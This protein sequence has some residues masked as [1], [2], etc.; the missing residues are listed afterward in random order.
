MSALD[1]YLQGVF[2]D[3]KRHVEGWKN[4]EGKSVLVCIAMGCPLVH[5]FLALQTQEWKDTHIRANLMISSTHAG[6]AEALSTLI[7]GSPYTGEHGLGY[8]FLFNILGSAP[9]F[10]W[11]LP[12][13]HEDKVVLTTRDR[14]YK[15]T[16]ADYQAIMQQIG[17]PR[18]KTLYTIVSG[19]D[20]VN[21]WSFRE[22][23]APGVPVVSWY[24]YNVATPEVLDLEQITHGRRTKEHFKCKT[25]SR[26]YGKPPNRGGVCLFGDGVVSVRD[27]QLI[28]L[29][30]VGGAGGGPVQHATDPEPAEAA[31]QEGPVAAESPQDETSESH[32]MVQQVGQDMPVDNLSEPS[33]AR[34]SFSDRIARP[35]PPQSPQRLGRRSAQPQHPAGYEHQILLAPVETTEHADMI[36]N[37]TMV[38]ELTYFIAHGSTPITSGWHGSAD[39]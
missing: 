14:A 37:P 30:K 35:V 28:C 23:R 13:F 34:T 9:S 25:V 3:L 24:G 18:R 27:A 1:L 7:S 26:S 17:E 19:M 11:M 33:E 8:G 10:A 15:G 12:K 32:P 39:L 5:Y 29:W 22:D 31:V 38:E 16:I 6:A 21:N 2:E 36:R 20:N 4:G